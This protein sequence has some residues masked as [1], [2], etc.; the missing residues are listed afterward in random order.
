MSN[1]FNAKL[2][3]INLNILE[4]K[5]EEFPGIEDGNGVLQELEV[6]IQIKGML[7]GI[8]EIT[9]LVYKFEVIIPIEFV[10]D[11]NIKLILNP[12]N[13]VILNHEDTSNAEVKL[14]ISSV[15]LN[16]ITNL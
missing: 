14:K 12:G 3:S 2:Q 6:G 13:E 10:N 4:P 16:S 5:F 9:P 8:E 1:L 11:N 15:I 7:E